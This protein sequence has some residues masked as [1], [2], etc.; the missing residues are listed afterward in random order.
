[1]PWDEFA[2]AVGLFE[3]EGTMGVYQWAKRGD[4]IVVMGVGMTD[5]DVI[6][7]FHRAVGFGRVT[8]PH[9]NRNVKP[10]WRWRLQNHRDS[11]ALL[12][13][14]LPYLGE[15]RRAR[16]VDILQ[17]IEERPRFKWPTDQQ[18]LGAA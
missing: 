18:E 11:H 9:K 12:V 3:G 13:R 5:E 4:K 10:I 16:A 7:R 15:R 2:W 17:W 6:R 14:M 1:M 8:G